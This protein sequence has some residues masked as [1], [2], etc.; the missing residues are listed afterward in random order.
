MSHPSFVQNAI[1][2]IKA[3]YQIILVVTTEEA[4]AEREIAAIAQ[5]Q[6]MSFITWDQIDGFSHEHDNADDSA[7]VN[8]VEALRNVP[9]E[10]TFETKHTL[11]VFKDLH[12]FYDSP[13]VRRTL[14]SLSERMVLNNTKQKRPIFLLQPSGRIHPDLASCVTAIEFTLP[15]PAQL[16]DIVEKTSRLVKTEA[17]RVCS[18]E[19]RFQIVQ[20]L[21]GLTSTEA[22]NC[23]TLCLIRHDGFNPS[24]VE[25]I[26]RTKANMLRKTEVLTYTPREDIPPL[27]ELGGYDE[28]IDFVRQR[29]LAYTPQ[30][31]NVKMDMPKG[32]ILV[33]VPGTGKS[34][35]GMS[36]AAALGLPFLEFDFSS[37]F[38]SLVGASE[39]RVR[40]V[41]SLVT[42]IDGC[43]LMIDEADKA[44]GGSMDATG[45]SGVTR[46]VFG[47][48]LTW[49]A[50][51]K[52]R[53]FVVMTM[54]RT[55]GMPPELLRKGR[56]DE[57]F[58]VD[59]PTEEERR[60]IFEIHMTK[61]DV[62]PTEYSQADWKK[63]L[64]ES[65]EFVGSEIEES[66]KSARFT[67]FQLATV[68][69]LI[70][71]HRAATGAAK[72]KIDEQLQPY[73]PEMKTQ[74]LDLP[75]S[76]HTSLLRAVPTAAQLIAAIKEVA[77]TRVTKVDKAN[78]DEIR[79]FGTERARPVSKS[80]RID[81]TAKSARNVDIAESN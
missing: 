59:M 34:V 33:G 75:V 15:T 56:F 78:I 63:F 1:E 16:E 12:N 26:E 5:Q 60:K 18:P 35:A 67:A 13:D 3:G 80:R 32:V 24:M 43:V 17:K 62:P 40:D 39:A 47:V 36:M 81:K 74:A 45:D 54:N 10:R 46:R 25:T 22:E 79:A 14:R 2:H 42:A 64:A 37:V 49:L 29:S 61:R 68:R 7:T 4:R 55:K 11:V 58:Y 76:E 72:Q 53:T 23:L 27:T 48:L 73:S 8:P 6:G 9:K 51:K 52:D 65:K 69:R 66:V 30:A 21:R 31:N 77:Q 19:L 70:D 44:L 57:I 20:G 38:N 41:I 71:E 28:L 50:R